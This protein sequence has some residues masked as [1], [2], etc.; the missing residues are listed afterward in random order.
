MF[1]YLN[2]PKTTKTMS[3]AW[4]GV[5]ILLM[6]SQ[7]KCLDME[8]ETWRE[9]GGGRRGADII[10]AQPLWGTQFRLVCD[11][12]NA[13]SAIIKNKLPNRGIPS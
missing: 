11:H 3:I 4:L 5:E 10:Y 2:P 6:G 13:V 7:E 12:T 9:Q 1:R 8:P